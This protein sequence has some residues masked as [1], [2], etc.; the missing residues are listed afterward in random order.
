LGKRIETFEENVNNNETPLISTPLINPAKE[1]ISDIS[2]FQARGIN[3]R[4]HKKDLFNAQP[5]L[6]ANSETSIY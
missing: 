4:P 5:W 6:D 2:L 3:T 1:G